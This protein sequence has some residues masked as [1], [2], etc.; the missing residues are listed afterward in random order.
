MATDPDTPTQSALADPAR[1]YFAARWLFLRALA[2]IYAVAFVSL[3]GQVLGLI[4]ANGILPATEYLQSEPGA[5]WAV[6][7]TLGWWWCSDAALQVYC[8]L[9]AGCAVLA[10][11]GV[12]AP[13][14]FAACWVLYLTLVH[15]GQD[16]LSF[17][18]DILL[19]ETGFLA[20]FFAPFQLLPRFRTEA[21]PSRIALW[22]LRWLL[23]RLMFFSGVVK[24]ADRTWTQLHALDYHYETQPLP[25]VLGWYAHHLPGPVQHFSVVILFI[26]ELVAPFAIFLPRVP[27]M[28]GGLALIFLQVLILLTGNFTFFNWLSIALC[29]L[30]FDDRAFGFVLR[31]FA[32]RAAPLPPH[33]WRP[34]AVFAAHASIAVLL[35]AT[36]LFYVVALGAGRAKV[37]SV[38]TALARA[39]QPY[40]LVNSYGLFAQMTTERDEIILEGS[41]DGRDWKA[42]EF[43]YKPGAVDRRP[44][45]VAPFQP[46]LDW[47]MWF[48]ALGSARQNPWFINLMQRI[49][50]G[51]PEVL[52]LLETNP[53][54]EHP[55]KYLR[56]QLYTY[57]FASLAEHRISGAWYTRTY[58]GPYFGPV[59]LR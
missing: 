23:F 48:A 7:P 20:I 14:M 26:I 34:R 51:R 53:F 22:L 5:S 40:Y 59:S 28:A 6:M 30:L 38:L 39:A 4:G 42:Y 9:G 41:D 2:V 36:S 10:A 16:F 12:A 46:R 17:Q 33:H 32:P 35:V 43:P 57:H 45:W 24:L 19:L 11:I 49:L 44:Q 55:P 3:R 21:P 18:W 27:R 37:P 50:E 58:K 31:R 29:L 56:A 25:T 52:A 54:R 47:Q 1:E 8:W 13:V 15:L